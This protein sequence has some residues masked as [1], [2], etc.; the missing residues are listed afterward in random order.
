MGGGERPAQG[1]E[2]SLAGS[3]ADA[4]QHDGHKDAGGEGG[5]PSTQRHRGAPKVPIGGGARGFG[6]RLHQC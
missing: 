3:M 4:H 5:K 2:R 1:S 6:D